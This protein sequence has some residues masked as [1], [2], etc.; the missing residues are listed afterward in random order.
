MECCYLIVYGCVNTYLGVCVAMS[1]HAF[2]PSM[3]VT[4]F[5]IPSEREREE[6]ENRGGKGFWISNIHTSGFL[7]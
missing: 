7:T 6:E 2:L 4:R 5:G 1:I 3:S